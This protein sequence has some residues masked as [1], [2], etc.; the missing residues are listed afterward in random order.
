[1]NSLFFDSVDEDRLYNSADW[2]M[3]FGLFIGN[4]VFA[5]PATSMQVIAK[6]KLNVFINPGKCFVNGR[7]GFCNGETLAISVGDSSKARYDAVVARLDMGRRDIHTDIIK[8]D[9]ANSLSEAVKPEPVREGLYYDIILAYI[10]VDAGTVTITDAIIEDVRM[11]NAVCGFVT[12]TVQQ[13]DTTNLFAQYQAAW[14]DFVSQL[15]NSDHVTINTED[16][17]GRKETI[18]IRD[19]LPFSSLFTVV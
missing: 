12:G 3:Y 19:Q 14:N 17:E 7:A 5:D 2:A 15:G 11:N 13:I 10:A 16:V 4:G 8:G 18:K 1:M 9:Y 6:G